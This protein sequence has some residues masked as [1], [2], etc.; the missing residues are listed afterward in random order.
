MEMTGGG[1]GA[2]G[3]VDMA[4]DGVIV[5]FENCVFE[6]CIRQEIENIQATQSLCRVGVAVAD[7]AVAIRAMT[8][9]FSIWLK[10][11][12]ALIT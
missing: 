12:H 4:V 1:A 5:G 10:H 3:V 2:E 7:V 8:V 11:R 6:L 9:S